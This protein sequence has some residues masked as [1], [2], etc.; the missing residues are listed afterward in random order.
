MVQT[1]PVL[2]R[3][4]TDLVDQ[5]NPE[6]WDSGRGEEVVRLPNETIYLKHKNNSDVVEY[7]IGHS[8]SGTNQSL[9]NFHRRTT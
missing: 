4:R 7:L 5:G 6:S 9:A 1:C 2:F 3:S 8:D